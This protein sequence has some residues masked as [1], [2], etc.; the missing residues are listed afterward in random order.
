MTTILNVIKT[1]LSRFKAIEKSK[2]AIANKS[3]ENHLSF[4]PTKA[5]L[6]DISKKTTVKRKIN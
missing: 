5:N 6:L 1:P 4:T 2:L 3:I